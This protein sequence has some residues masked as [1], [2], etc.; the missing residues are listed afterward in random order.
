[1]RRIFVVGPIAIAAV[2]LATIAVAQDESNDNKT[3]S[4]PAVSPSST[5]LERGEY[6][7]HHV[8][9][10]IICHSPKD[11]R[12]E[13]I[14]DRAFE[15]GMIPAK[16]TIPGMDPWASNA[17]ALKPLAGGRTEEMIEF[18]Q[19]G[20]WPDNM[21]DKPRPPMPPF[22]LSEEDARAVVM[23]LKTT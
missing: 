3:E 16:P 23:Y 4:E 2:V 6:I 19:T 12:G 7:T 21:R 1:M 10:C 11:Q 14:L 13:P 9:M 20:E 8:A 15:G 22:R 17:P 5:E 18:L